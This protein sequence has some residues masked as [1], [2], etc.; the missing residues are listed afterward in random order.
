MGGSSERLDHPNTFRLFLK[1]LQFLFR[2][3]RACQLSKIKGDV[4]LV[5][6]TKAP[7]HT[8]TLHS[9]AP[10]PLASFSLFNLLSVTFSNA[11]S[12]LQS[13][14]DSE[15][16]KRHKRNQAELWRK[17]TWLHPHCCTSHKYWM[18][19]SAS[20]HTGDQVVQHRLSAL[21]HWQCNLTAV[22]YNS[23]AYFGAASASC[24]ISLPPT[25]SLGWLTSPQPSL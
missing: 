4:G 18:H 24:S 9:A 25:L 12:R 7:R 23:L 20:Q 10:A 14:S 19:L 3:M 8:H 16:S 22:I 2:Q 13:Y 17:Q 5:K 11:Y 6:T 15:I 1:H 21:A